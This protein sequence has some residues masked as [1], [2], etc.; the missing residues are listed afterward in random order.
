MSE[1]GF[2]GHDLESMTAVIA[3]DYARVPTWRKQAAAYRKLAEL[4]ELH[5]AKVTGH[6][7]NA[8][9]YWSSRSTSV[10]R[11]EGDN[12]AASFRR[13]LVAV[14]GN[15]RALDAI[16]DEIEAAKARMDEIRDEWVD[17]QDAYAKDPAIFK[18]GIV[19][20]ASTL[21]EAKA[22][23]DRAARERMHA[24]SVTTTQ[25]WHTDMHSPG[26][27]LGPT[28]GNEPR[29]PLRPSDGSGSGGGQDT[30]YPFT[31]HPPP[32]G[33]T[34]PPEPG[35]SIPP[36]ND[37]SLEFPTPGSPVVTA[38]SGPPM[39]GPAPVAAPAFQPSAPP[40]NPSLFSPTQPGVPMRGGVP[41]PRMSPSV[42]GQRPAQPSAP[43]MTARPA[44][45]RGVIRNPRQ[46]NVSGAMPRQARAA[47]REDEDETFRDGPDTDELFEGLALDAVA[48]VVRPEAPPRSVRRRDVGPVLRRKWSG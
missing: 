9:D 34:T 42:L 24:M 17:L 14:S 45:D 30:T 8:M 35:G 16:A 22:A 27:Y 47:E 44:A 41:A 18:K 25:A 19:E 4:A 36:A 48:D 29:V 12:I 3:A 40:V 23:Y 31:Y 37:P 28:Y 5:E 32:N 11:V 15:A 6:V 21:Q 43:A 46:G 20:G 26:Q 2:E 39:S 1:Y 10:V 33:M 38:P 7:L 13:G